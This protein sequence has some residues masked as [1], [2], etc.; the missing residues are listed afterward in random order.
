MAGE[1]DAELAMLNSAIDSEEYG[2]E[3]R[4]RRALLLIRGTPMAKVDTDIL[5][6][7]DLRTVI[8]GKGSRASDVIKSIE[9]LK[10]SDSQWLE[11]TRSALLARRVRG[12]DVGAFADA[13]MFDRRG[14][15]V[16]AE[17]LKKWRPDD[18]HYPASLIGG[19]C[20]R[21]AAEALE[22]GANKDISD[23]FNYACARW[24]VDSSPSPQL[25][26]V[27]ISLASADELD[28]RDANYDQCIALAYGVIGNTA[29]ALR[30]LGVSRKKAT[31]LPVNVFS[32]WRFLHARSADFLADLD[33]MERQIASGTPLVPAFLVKASVEDPTA[34]S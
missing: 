6:K 3:A 24:G 17:L 23:A 12:E 19:G 9:L 22:P 5:A 16:A 8:V 10:Q 32:C 11:F 1:K 27:A 18:W 33:E 21:E 31:N 15:R 30:L 29:E 14:A 13:L 26:S 2:L 28:K 34:I 7:E 20:F 4:S 25:F